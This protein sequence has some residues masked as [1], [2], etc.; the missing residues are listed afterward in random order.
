M[1]AFSCWIERTMVSLEEEGSERK[2]VMDW[3]RVGKGVRWV[4]VLGR[5]GMEESRLAKWKGGGRD[6]AT[7]D[8]R[9]H[10]C[11]GKR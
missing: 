11:R 10:R 5:R 6:D 8:K 4:T 9:A 1:E 3:R 2:V 7:R